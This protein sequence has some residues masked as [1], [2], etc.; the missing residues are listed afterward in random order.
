MSRIQRYIRLKEQ[1]PTAKL[2]PEKWV[3]EPCFLYLLCGWSE[4]LK[5]RTLIGQIGITLCHRRLRPAYKILHQH[6]A[7]HIRY[8]EKMLLSS[9]YYPETT[10]QA[11]SLRIVPNCGHNMNRIM[12]VQLP[13]SKALPTWA[14]RPRA[15]GPLWGL[16]HL[17][18]QFCW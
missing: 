9:I 7:W 10:G 18:K 13:G 6:S 12:C 1:T 15:G 2:E 14:L 3:N 17:K 4:Y 5:Y 16:S 8:T 11:W